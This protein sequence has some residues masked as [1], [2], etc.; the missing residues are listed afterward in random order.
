[1]ISAYL[2]ELRDSSLV[3]EKLTDSRSLRACLGSLQESLFRLQSDLPG[4]MVIKQG[5]NCLNLNGT[6]YHATC[7]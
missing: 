7:V 6:L 1:M 2:I 3:F 4:L 5:V